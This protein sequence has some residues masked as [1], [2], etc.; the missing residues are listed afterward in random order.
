MT[1]KQNPGNC[2]NETGTTSEGLAHV[3]SSVR[4]KPRQIVIQR[5]HQPEQEGE[6]K[7]VSFRYSCLNVGTLRGR[8]GEIVEMLERRNLDV[9]CA[10]E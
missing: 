5:L 1:N 3:R 7:T 10:Q 9:C 6:E 2:V 4:C 8:S